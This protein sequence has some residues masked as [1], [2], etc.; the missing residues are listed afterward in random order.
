MSYKNHIYFASTLALLSLSTALFINNN[1]KA[2]ADYNT[3][4][5]QQNNSTNTINTNNVLV[6]NSNTTSATATT[7]SASAVSRAYDGTP[8]IPIGNSNYP[9]V[10]A[11]DVSGF[12][13]GLTYN[14]FVSLKN[15]GVKTAIVK[16]TEG[17]YY[18]NPYDG[19]QVT[20]ARNAGLNVQVYH[21]AKFN[22]WNAAVSE[23]NYLANEMNHLG[24][25]SNTMIYADMEDN[26]TK[27]VG[28]ANN[29]N[30]F[31]QQLNNRGFT[32]HGV[33]A[34]TSYDA[35]YNVSSTVGRNRTWIAQYLYNPTYST[36]QNYGAWQ[37][38]SH[39]R[40]AGYNGDLDISVD[41]HGLFGSIST[42]KYNNGWQYEV[43]G[44]NA[45]GWQN[46][47]DNWYFFDNNGTARTGWF[48]SPASGYWYYFNQD[49]AAQTGWQTINN[50][51]YYF[52]PNN[53]WMLAGLQKINGNYY[54]F[55][56]THDGFYGAMKT[57]WQNI[58]GH[59]YYFD[60]TGKAVTEDQYIEG[61]LYEFS[62]DGQLIKEY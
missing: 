18:T 41:Y 52:D 36:N 10:D 51:S 39:G 53:A 43:N 38:N 7:Q 44:Q 15:A 33:Y 21:Y 5:T 3:V 47:N 13:A 31:W 61:H 32:N 19:Q 50:H 34:S 35:T 22:S 55:Q 27:Y 9:R 28:I 17:T 24:L 56:T 30:G 16:L 57:G 46:I 45:T 1:A 11:V 8:I 58:N 40:I 49:G 25:S 59:R 48:Q 37:F 62:S 26:S 54:N 4:T 14:N 29:L 60:N 6:N 2:D 12:Q 42:W 20:N 23:A